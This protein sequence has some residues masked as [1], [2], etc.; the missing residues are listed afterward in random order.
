MLKRW[1]SDVTVLGVQILVVCLLVV[2]TS[3]DV[4]AQSA[5]TGALAGTVTDS[6]GGVLQHAQI[7]LRNKGTGET[8]HRYH[9]SDGSY[10]FSLLPPG[11][12][13]VTVEAV[14]LCGGRDARGADS[15]Y[16]G[17]ESWHAAGSARRENRTSSSELRSCKPTTSHSA[18]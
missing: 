9:R 12:Y 13:E 18:G 2:V 10:R 3:L 11:E 15:D 6:T 14:G 5:S 7:T 17:E 16:R 4:C 1:R 8:L